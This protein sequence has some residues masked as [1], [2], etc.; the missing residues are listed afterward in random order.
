VL[1]YL[2][3]PHQA[4]ATLAGPDGNQP[5]PLN[6]SA[7]VTTAIFLQA[8]QTLSFDSPVLYSGCQP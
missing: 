3:I 4:K 6:S 7:Q 1:T 5:V 8:G 2:N